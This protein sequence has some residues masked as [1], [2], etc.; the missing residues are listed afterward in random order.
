M[1]LQNHA[2]S[3]NLDPTAMFV[4]GHSAGGHLAQEWNLRWSD[5]E[6]TCTHPSGCPPAAGAIGIEGIYDVAAWDAYDASNW[7]GQFSC[8]TRKAFA[9]S[10]GDCTDTTYD[11]P[12]WDVGSPEYLAR[13][14]VAMGI[15][16]AGHVLII[17]SPGDDWVDVA[18]ATD[19]GAAMS[20]AF[21]DIHVITSTDGACAT[22]QHNDPLTQTI[23][24]TC[25]VNFVK[26]GGSGI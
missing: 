17:H 11:R 19:F 26:S 7:R 10:P 18:E 20:A 21:P 8:A 25:I 6:Q 5:F 16:P 1:W 15:A 12:C 9:F 2:A 3:Y 13:N 22:G 4:G 23:L 24:A 14:S